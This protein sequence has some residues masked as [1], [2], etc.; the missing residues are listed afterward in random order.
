MTTL[1]AG[2]VTLPEVVTESS[3]R[4]GAFGPRDVG[5]AGGAATGRATGVAPGVVESRT[6]VA[7]APA[8]PASIG[9]TSTTFGGAAEGHP[10]TPALMVRAAA[11]KTRFVIAAA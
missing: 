9:S 5:L 10:T 8:L 2:T 6:V 4:A 3:D 1:P 7:F 11:A